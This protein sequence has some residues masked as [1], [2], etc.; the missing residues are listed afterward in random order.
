MLGYVRKREKNYIFLRRHS[1][2]KIVFSD[3]CS[4]YRCLYKI[5]FMPMGKRIPTVSLSRS[6]DLLLF[7]LWQFNSIIWMILVLAF[8]HLRKRY[9]SH[10]Q[11]DHRQPEQKKKTH[12]HRENLKLF[13]R[14]TLKMKRMSNR[15]VR[16]HTRRDSR[17]K[18][19]TN[20]MCSL[21][22]DGPLHAYVSEF[23]HVYL[24][25]GW[26]ETGLN[27]SSSLSYVCNGYAPVC[28]RVCAA[29]SNSIS[30]TQCFS[31]N[32]DICLCI[33]TKKKAKKNL[34]WGKFPE[35]VRW[36]FSLQYSAD[37]RKKHF[38][39]WTKWRK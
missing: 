23:F 31:L 7:L 28:V 21:C 32:L 33:V 30:Y 1:L 19:L 24:I 5:S 2:K 8:A 29:P 15:K 36:H 17:N 13:Q 14:K 20:Q 3:T 6:S 26:N 9:I 16:A 27:T 18:T 39:V 22:S 37:A 10:I 38:N 25:V 11:R 35:Y 12:S 34:K 4:W